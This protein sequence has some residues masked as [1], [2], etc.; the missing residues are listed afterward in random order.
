M[1]GWMGRIFSSSTASTPK[2]LLRELEP[3]EGVEPPSST[4]DAAA[5]PLSYLGSADE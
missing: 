1:G 4:Y 5:L 3:S 2:C